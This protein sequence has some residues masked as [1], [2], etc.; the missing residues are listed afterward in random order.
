MKLHGDFKR[1]GMMVPEAAAVLKRF[2]FVLREMVRI[3]AGWIPGTEHWETKLYYPESVWQDEL[4]AWQLRERVLE[5][6]YP[7]RRIEPGSD[8]PCLAFWRALGDAP[9]STAFASA[10]FAHAKPSLASAFSGYLDAAD[11][12]DDAPTVRILKHA[13]QDIREQFVRAA[14]DGRNRTHV[15]P[16]DQQFA[17]AWCEAVK[18]AFAKLPEYWWNP[19][20]DADFAGAEA[21]LASLRTPLVVARRGVRDRRFKR[22]LFSW[23]DSLAPSRGAGE[24]L[25]LQVRQAQAHLNEIWATEMAAACIY[26]LM[27]EAPAEFLHDAARWCFDEVRHCRM[28]YTRFADWGF[29]KSEMP[30]GSFSYDLGEN[31][32]PLTRVGVIFYFETTYIHTKSERTKSF[33]A[34]GDRTSS[35]DMDFDWADELI[36]TYYGKHWLEY[37]LKREGKGRTLNEI[38]AGA[39]QAVE[40]IR[41]NATLG[42]AADTERLYSETMDKARLLAG[43]RVP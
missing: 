29:Q 15:M 42:D 19:S 26:D 43:A 10:F 2:Y 32:D 13:L 3:Q 12:L 5:L 17:A 4:T 37:F 41:K 25:E 20:E 30:L 23:P 9:N 34:F 21:E 7:E 28:G 24:G 6:R 36:H 22:A 38:K 1:S 40:E 8:A 16:Q 39:L 14:E 27:D 35:H 11:S 18:R 33:A 31:L